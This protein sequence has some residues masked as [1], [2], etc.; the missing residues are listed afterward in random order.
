MGSFPGAG[1]MGS[2][3][4]MGMGN[5]ESYKRSAERG[6]G[7]AGGFGAPS[8]PRPLSR[9]VGSGS[10][11]SSFMHHRSPLTPIRRIPNHM[12]WGMLPQSPRSPSDIVYEYRNDD[13]E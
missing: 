9:N 3:G 7:T 8:S 13:S 11:S 1:E 6:S 4:G 2:P 12:V 10:Y 5:P